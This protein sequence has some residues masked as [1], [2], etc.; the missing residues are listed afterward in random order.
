MEGR[1]MP[2]C[3]RMTSCSIK[4]AGQEKAVVYKYMKCQRLAE[5]RT[6]LLRRFKGLA[7]AEAAGLTVSTSGSLFRLATANENVFF[8][9]LPAGIP[10]NSMLAKSSVFIQSLISLAV[11]VPLKTEP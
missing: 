2:L 3:A 10:T 11:P 1:N 9:S 7:C 6:E 4:A 5:P 8:L